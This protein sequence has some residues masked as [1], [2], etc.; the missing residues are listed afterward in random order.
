MSY[1]AI[2]IAEAVTASLP[3]GVLQTSLLFFTSSDPLTLL[4]VLEALHAF[5]PPPQ[6]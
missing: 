3:N 4:G 2:L 6:P 5:A 1:K